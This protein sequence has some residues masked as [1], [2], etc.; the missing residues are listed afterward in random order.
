MIFL[1]KLLLKLGHFLHFRQ[2]LR[3]NIIEF[4]CFNLSLNLFLFFEF[5][6]EFEFI[7]KIKEKR[8][9]EE[10]IFIDNNLF[11]LAFLR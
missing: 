6:I 10:R 11:I 7:K 9:N 5:K 8:L 1:I 2:L 4:E 3:D